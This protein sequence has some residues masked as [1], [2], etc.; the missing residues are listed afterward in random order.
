MKVLNLHLVSDSSGETTSTVSRASA[1]RFKNIKTREYLWP[2]VRVEEEIDAVIENIKQHSGVVIYTISDFRLRQK[3]RMQCKELNIP[4]VSA[5]G[6]VVLEIAKYLDEEVSN[7]E[8][9]AQWKLGEEYFKRIETFNFTMQHDDGQMVHE[10]NEADILL[11]GVSR[12]SK[13]PTSFYLAHRGY[14]VANIPYVRGVLFPV[15]IEKITKPLIV[16]L[17]INHDRLSQLRKMRL[18]DVAD[19]YKHNDGYTNVCDVQMELREAHNFLMRYRIPILD[20]SQ[21]AIEETSAEI[22]KLYNEKK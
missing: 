20:I 5:I 2:L 22:I 3:L 15:D 6:A 8:P 17:T 14:K 16:G 18:I 11:I 13:S 9:G 12:T 7:A 10:A 1:A 4:C 19:K 21:K